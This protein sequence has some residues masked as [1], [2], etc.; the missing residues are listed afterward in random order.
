MLL[1][2][3]GIPRLLAVAGGS[4]G[5]M[6]ALEWCLAYP[7]DVDSCITTASTGRLSSQGLAWNAIARNAIMAD[8][9]WQGGSYYGTG[10]AP[11]AGIGIARQVGHV[12]YLSRQS[13]ARKFGRDLQEREEYSYTVDGADFAVESYL[14]HQ[15]A[16]FAG[17]FDANSYIYIS[18]ALTYFDLARSYGGSLERA[19]ERAC[20]R[21]LLLSFT[22][23]WLYPSEDSEAL[24]NA[25]R[26]NGKDATHHII[27]VPYGHDSF[28]LDTAHQ[29]PLIAE[30][31]ARVTHDSAR[32][33]GE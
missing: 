20:S 32:K 13:M 8:P 31:L 24:L 25:L 1:D 28:I 10:R 9:D 5:G 26:A 11:T 27:D 16:S 7:D 18:R 2:E 3:L 30:F 15:A 23:D 12:T 33:H 22:S 6:Q 19:M 17:R 4:L 29:T 21:F 14:R